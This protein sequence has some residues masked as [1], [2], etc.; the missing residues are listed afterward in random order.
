MPRRFLTAEDVRRAAGPEI[1]VDESTVVTPHALEAARAAG[2]TI[3]TAAGPWREPA[4]DRGPD[5]EGGVHRPPHLPEPPAD[6]QS[7]TAV[8][9]AVGRNRPGVLA[10]ITAALA[11]LGANIHDVTQ[12]IVA[13]YF[14]IVFVVEL[15]GSGNFHDLKSKLECMGGPEDYAVNV[16][17]ERA[18]RFMHRV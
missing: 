4:P 8:V 9:T 5:A 16:M 10:E 1:V 11:E 6:T 18:F 14:H 3:K 17:H 2:V 15:G 13:D 12:R 7:P